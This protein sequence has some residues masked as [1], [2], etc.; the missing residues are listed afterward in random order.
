MVKLQ[1]N[2]NELVLPFC[3]GTKRKYKFIRSMLSWVFSQVNKVQSNHTDMHAHTPTPIYTYIQADTQVQTHKHV[4]MFTHIHTHTRTRVHTCEHA[5]TH[6]HTHTRLR[7]KP[8]TYV[9]TSQ[10]EDVV[11][12]VNWCGNLSKMLYL[13]SK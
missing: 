4:D 1:K 8:R 7:F 13:H 10:T 6:T 12:N 3:K 9:P 5:R 2:N 11:N